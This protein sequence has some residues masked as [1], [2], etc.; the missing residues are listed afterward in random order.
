MHEMDEHQSKRD[1]DEIP[2]ADA[3]G[4]DRSHVAHREKPTH[5]EHTKPEGDLRHGPDPT[6]RP[7][8]EPRR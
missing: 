4:H 5:P 6:E 7:P 2:A 8:R 1:T 3:G